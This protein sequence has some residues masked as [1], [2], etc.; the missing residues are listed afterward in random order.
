MLDW[1]T[2][3]CVV[4]ILILVGSLAAALLIAGS[5]VGVV[6]G[7]LLFITLIDSLIWAHN[8]L[9]HV[10]QAFDTHMLQWPHVRRVSYFGMRWTFRA[11]L[12]LGTPLVSYTYWY[13]YWDNAGVP[14]AHI[15]LDWQPLQIGHITDAR[16]EVMIRMTDANGEYRHVVHYEQIPEQVRNA[17]ISAED[18]DFWDNDGW[19]YQRTLIAATKVASS[20]R[21]Q[22]GSTITQQVVRRVDP[23][24]VDLARKERGNKLMVDN[25]LTRS[26]AAWKGRAAANRSVRK[27][28][29]IK[30]AVWMQRNLEEHFRVIGVNDPRL[31]AKKIILT[32]YLNMV[33]FSHGVYGVDYAAQFF[34]QKDLKDLSVPEAALLASLLPAPDIYINDA[35][36]MIWRRNQVLMRM[37]K[38]GYLTKH[39]LDVAIAAPLGLDIRLA[40]T[41]TQ[42]PAA[43][44][45]TFREL[46]K[47]GRP[48]G[49][50]LRGNVQ[51]R[52]TI[53]MDIQKIVT[54][55]VHH[56]LYGDGMK[57]SGFAG[58]YPETE[59][60]QAAVVV[61]GTHGEV[62]AMSGGDITD[63]AHQYNAHMQLN[64]VFSKEQPGSTIKIV[65]GMA[66]MA[67]GFTPDTLVSDAPISVRMGNGTYKAISNYESDRL[68]IAP[69]REFSARS[70]NTAY[71]HL[72][73]DMVG[74]TPEAAVEADL[75]RQRLG[76]PVDPGAAFMLRWAEYMGVETPL[77]PYISTVLGGSDVTIMDMANV[78]HSAGT[79]KRAV[80]YIISRITDNDGHVLYEN[81]GHLTDLPVPPEQVEML[82]EL[83][84]GNVRLPKGTGHSLDTAEFGIEV[85]GKTGTSNDWRDAWYCGYTQNGLFI[86]VHVGYDDNK[87]MPGEGLAIWR[88]A[89]GGWI[90]LPIFREIVARCYGPG[91][92]MGMPQPMPDPVKNGVNAYL[93]NAYHIPAK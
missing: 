12:F 85:A 58:R 20:H 52:T 63:P 50:L 55:A 66:A 61:L 1:I 6:T 36:G 24:I 9:M 35:P 21:L 72:M 77:Q 31:E 64:R 84:Y 93:A 56:G 11:A 34:F 10:F 82:Q 67:A 89:S 76:H 14:D 62:L 16:G 92:P 25:I 3:F 49:Q 59:I 68:G 29:E 73:H 88:R 13:V 22:G 47:I 78:I 65:D 8:R 37:A 38:H 70:V 41:K 18:G 60:P 79:G 30:H 28:P 54:E 42:A 32:T 87:P 86:A 43:V 39:Q 17:F 27:W 4:A 44:N 26:L 19:E 5:L 45:T 71:M 90:A 23:F 51:I 15:I 91:R 53:R 57:G 80:P 81:N 69:L 48:Q 75:L 40:N 46:T 74:H 2:A 7:I 33:Y 83:L